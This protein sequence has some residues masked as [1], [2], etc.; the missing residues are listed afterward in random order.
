MVNG[1]DI[2]V[3][4]AKSPAELRGRRCVELVIES[5][6]LFTEVEKAQATSPPASRVIITA[7]AKG[8]CLTVVMGVNDGNTTR[9]GTRLERPCTEHSPVY[10]AQGRV[11][12]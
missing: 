8:D 1:Q 6:G 11:Q 4:S 7:P 9:P 5:T 12:H 10:V 3:V 2:K